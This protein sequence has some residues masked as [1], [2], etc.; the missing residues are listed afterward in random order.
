MR[1]YP[2]NSGKK[3]SA[4]FDSESERAPVAI[5]EEIAKWIA[6]EGYRKVFEN[7]SYEIYRK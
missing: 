6:S 3:R 4:A 7:D 1:G 2:E 5:P